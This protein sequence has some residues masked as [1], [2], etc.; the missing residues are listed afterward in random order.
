MNG[1]EILDNLVMCPGIQ[2]VKDGIYEIM[3][4]MMG[5]DI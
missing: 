1:A 2:P 5:I 3:P 4:Y